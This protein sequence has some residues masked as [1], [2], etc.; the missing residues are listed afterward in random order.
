MHKLTEQIG[1]VPATRPIPEDMLRR[2]KEQ[3]ERLDEAVGFKA[4]KD[5]PRW[6]LLPFGPVS[7]IV[8]VLTFGA[9]KYADNNWKKVPDARARYLAA[10]F[11]HLAAYAQGERADSETGLSHLAHAGCCLLFLNWFEGRSEGVE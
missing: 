8:D 5:K 6:D 7:E 3:G 1:C 11:R 9:R 2:L 10:A 4:D